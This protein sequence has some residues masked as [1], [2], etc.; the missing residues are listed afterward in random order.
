MGDGGFV[1]EGGEI[2]DGHGRA[3]GRGEGEPK[4]GMTMGRVEGGEGERRMVR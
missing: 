4:S 2:N 1:G 3:I